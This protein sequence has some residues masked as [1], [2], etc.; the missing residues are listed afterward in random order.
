M[1]ASSSHQQ[2]HFA[3]GEL[4]EEESEQQ[5]VHLTFICFDVDQ[6]MDAKEEL[7]IS[8]VVG[9]VEPVAWRFRTNAPTRYIVNPARGILHDS[10]SVKVTIELVNNR[11][12]PNHKLTLQAMKVPEGSSEKTV[13]KH[14]N[15]RSF[16]NVQTIGL[17]LSTMLMNIEYTEYIGQEKEANS[18]SELLRNIMAQ[19]ST[20]G[21]D[22][23][24]EL[25][26]LFD[27][28]Q[29][30]T[31]EIRSNVEQT[32]KLKAVLEKALEARKTTQSELKLRLLEEE[33]QTRKWKDE[34]L[35]KEAELQSAQQVQ[36][37]LAHQQQC[38]IS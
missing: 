25:D 26:N 10:E 8:R 38:A 34:L 28:L 1:A 35:K 19:S 6:V 13:W 30:D 14:K 17:K 29:A 33:K 37:A 21:V 36:R 23:I 5:F 18:G 32:I 16:T 4:S 15:A 31:L 12:H 11:F 22:R 3:P 24:K 20:V 7:V 2:R 27:M 9:L